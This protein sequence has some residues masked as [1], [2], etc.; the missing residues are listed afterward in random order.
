M[1][2]SPRVPTILQFQAAECALAALAMMMAHHGCVVPLEEL[3]QRSGVSG[4]GTSL[5]A[6]KA[7]ATAYGFTTRVFRKEPEAVAAIGFPCMVFVDFNHMLVVE[8]M[9]PRA[10]TV[11]DPAGGRR[12]IGTAEFER[13]FTGIVVRLE[14]TATMIPRRRSGGSILPA[15][16]RRKWIWGGLAVTLAVA[17]GGAQSAVA[18]A[19][20]SGL[21]ALPLAAAVA[22]LLGL[23]AALER[24]SQAVQDAA[25]SM[26]DRLLPTRAASYFTLRNPS[27][28]MSTAHA[29]RHLADLIRER[30]AA[31]I[32]GLVAALV[33]WAVL[34][35]LSPQTAA[36]VAA[37]WGI[38]AIASARTF[39]TAGSS[40]RR[41]RLNGGAMPLAEQFI[42]PEPWQVSGRED[43]ALAEA[44]AATTRAM[45]P[46]SAFA[47]ADALLRGIIATTLAAACAVAL[48]TTSGLAVPVLALLACG[49]WLRVPKAMPALFSLRDLAGI[50]GDLAAAPALPSPPPAPLMP[51][52]AV[53]VHGLTFAHG[54]APLFADLAWSVATGALIGLTGPAGVGKTT[55][56]RL[57]AGQMAPQA[58]T[59]AIGGKI[60]LVPAA[61]ALFAASIADNVACWRPEI[62]RTRIEAVLRTVDLWDEVAARPDGMDSQV[63]EDAVNL[64][65]GQRRRLML[66]RALAGAPDIVV[67]DETLD[68][69]D[70]EG[71]KRI[72]HN[73]RD[74]GL[75]VILISQRRESL[76]ACDAAWQLNAGTCR[77]WQEDAKTG[78]EIPAASA[79]PPPA[80]SPPASPP[81]AATWAALVAAA[82]LLGLALPDQPTTTAACPN[83]MRPL[84]WLARQHGLL[85]FPVS[86]HDDCWYRRGDGIM[87]SRTNDDTAVVLAPAILGGYRLRTASGTWHRL[88]HRTAVT[89][90]PSALLVLRRPA[91]TAEHGTI[92]S[93][94]HVAA[95]TLALWLGVVALATGGTSVAAVIAIGIGTG[96][97]TL[98]RH[99]LRDR[100]RLDGTVFAAGHALRLSPRWTRR[101]ST[102]RLERWCE[103]IRTLAGRRDTAMAEAAAQ[104]VVI[105]GLSLLSPQPGLTAAAAGTAAVLML[106]LGRQLERSR[107]KVQTSEA[108]AIAFLHPLLNLLPWCLGTQI[109]GTA[110]GQW[111]RLEEASDHRDRHRHRIATL[112]ISWLTLSPLAG[113]TVSPELAIAV[114]IGNGLGTALDS[115]AEARRTRRQVRGI[116]TA[117]RESDGHV[118][119]QPP[120]TVTADDASFAYD[121]PVLHHVSLAIAPGEIVA[122]AGPSGCGK[123]TLMRLLMGFEPP[124][125][126]RILMNGQD[127]ATA[128]RLAW[129]AHAAAVFQDERLQFRSLHA[130]VRGLAPLHL[131]QVAARLAQIGL[132][133]K[134]AALPMGMATLVDS[135]FLSEGQ[136][137]QVMLAR[138]LSRQPSLLFLDETLAAMDPAARGLA[139]AAIRA[140]GATCVLTSHQ[141]DVLAAVD[142]IVWLKDGRLRHQTIH[143][144]PAPAI[145][146]AIASSTTMDQLS[147]FGSAARLYR[148]AAIT[149]I[150]GPDRRDILP[151]PAPSPLVAV[152]VALAAAVLGPLF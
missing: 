46:A 27:L 145:P 104:A 139:L 98:A 58:G 82:A 3:R 36:A 103:D 126:G 94:W 118:P 81:D 72:L 107:R 33:P 120:T 95:A 117:P 101:L 59:V 53:V 131:D 24:W 106:T 83:G 21:T 96:A 74:L 55:L 64:S 4:D 141:D 140:S 26:I 108:T 1:T 35:G 137:A 112:R 45:D 97:L 60:A 39:L 6:L 73:L 61:P 16:I 38:C 41:M 150:E 89:L 32:A 71:E 68:A 115:L 80:I 130:Q 65:G 132:W 134:V 48:A 100:S 19:L 142:R 116:Q 121:R 51:G 148:P 37:A 84:D 40:W 11:V 77:P 30:P 151:E 102:E 7:V 136:A 152:F 86:L 146:P 114:V 2:A 76:A 93:S 129:R 133:S 91:D 87:L 147:A 135:R 70:A 138:A 54:H 52:H 25:Q 111:R 92:F 62:D 10:L 67:L 105:A 9:T 23:H 85:L 88:D 13:M 17:L 144:A 78:D 34:A 122:I 110:H 56:S 125:A 20:D 44:V 109:A 69:V 8:A 66:A 149:R 28:L 31:V 143:R 42:A 22:A 127:L 12:Q 43:E 47:R 63:A 14:P 49:P 75:T 123:S 79:W 99:R 57:L 113:L 18:L 5:A 119:N 29:G 128:D 15:L 124:R 50:L 90:A